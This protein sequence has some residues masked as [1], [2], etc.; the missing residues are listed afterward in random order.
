MN[1]TE[2]KFCQDGPI[3][4]SEADF[5]TYTAIP[6]RSYF[7]KD[8]SAN[9]SDLVDIWICGRH[10]DGVRRLALRD[11]LHQAPNGKSP[12]PLPHHHTTCVDSSNGC[13]TELIRYFSPKHDGSPYYL[14]KFLYNNPALTLELYEEFYFFLQHDPF[15]IDST[16][17]PGKASLIEIL[18]RCL[19]DQALPLVKFYRSYLED[20]CLPD[21]ENTY[22]KDSRRNKRI[23]AL[24]VMCLPDAPKFIADLIWEIF[25]DNFLAAL[26]SDTFKIDSPYEADK[27]SFPLVTNLISHV[28]H[29]D[30]PITPRLN[31]YHLKWIQLLEDYLPANQSYFHRWPDLIPKLSDDT[32]A[33]RIMQRHI[34][35]FTPD[36][37]Y[38][39]LKDPA[40]CCHLD[41]AVGLCLRL[42]HDPAPL[43]R[44]IRDSYRKFLARNPYASE[45]ITVYPA[46]APTESE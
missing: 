16:T 27:I 21:P 22:Q 25:S 5:K 40:K 45:I 24:R 18:S 26:H 31:P 33:L 7:G 6:V 35:N 32:L 17:L 30:I 44:H 15:L 23:E 39:Y 28:D 10:S 41:Q 38:D 13:F 9:F 29:V 8:Y 42:G 19:G 20:L 12:S 11:A 34:L 1:S 36:T 3:A 37:T 14:Y 46:L 2:F 4:I 43:Q